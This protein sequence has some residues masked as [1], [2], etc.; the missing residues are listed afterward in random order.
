MQF[1]AGND[2]GQGAHGDFILV[3]DPPAY[4]SL[5]VKRVEKCRRSAANQ[6]KLLDEIGQRAVPEGTART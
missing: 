4:P 6:R 5:V 3:S 2:E 1:V